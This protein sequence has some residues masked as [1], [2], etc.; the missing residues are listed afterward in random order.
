MVF[1]DG[2]RQVG[3]TTLAKALIGTK[4]KDTA[5]FNW[6]NQRERKQITA[7][8][9][10]GTAELIILDE[11]HKFKGWKRFI[12]GEYDVHKDKYRFLVT[13]SSRL[14][15]YRKGGDS[16]QGRYRHYRLHPF[17]LAELANGKCRIEPFKELPIGPAWDG[18]ELGI[19]E[20]FGGFPEP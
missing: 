10:P 13:G 2:P 5:Y 15:I 3:K 17:S 12:K 4:F 19:L 6:D 1:V 18:P 9:W 8:Q 14:D 7:A 20:R 11:I 16:L